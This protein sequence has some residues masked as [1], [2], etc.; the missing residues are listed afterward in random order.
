MRNDCINAVSQALGRPLKAGEAQKIEQRIREHKILLANQ[1]RQAYLGMSEVQ[2][3][4]AAAKGAAEQL[5]AEAAKKQQR[6]GLTIL[7]NQRLSDYFEQQAGAMIDN[8]DRTL[9]PRFDGKDRILSADTK[10]RVVFNEY[11]R[12]L[13]D[14]IESFGPKLLG[15]IQNDAA[16]VPVFRELRGTDTRKPKPSPNA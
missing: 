15:I 14:A 6:I 12:N 5:K 9:A 1:D 3:L 7:A 10:Y 16:M 8:V 2:R 4:Q 13:S 11:T